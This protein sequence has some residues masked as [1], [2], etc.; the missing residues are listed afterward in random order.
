MSNT[1]FLVVLLDN[2][3]YFVALL[4]PNL[5]VLYIILRRKIHS[6]IDPSFMMFLTCSFA[7]TVPC[8]LFCLHLISTDKFVF[9]ILSELLF[10]TGFNI[11][12]NGNRLK[13]DRH[14][15]QYSPEDLHKIFLLFFLLT[16]VITLYSYS[17]SGVPIFQESRFAN[18][19]NPVTAILGRMLALPNTYLILYSYHIIL[20]D[21]ENVIKRIQVGMCFAV[22]LIISF[23]SGS[24]G[25]ILVYVA[26]YFAYSFFFKNSPIHISLKYVIIIIISPIPVITIYYGSNGLNGFFMLLFR[27]VAGGDGYWQGFVNNVIDDIENTALWYERL[28]SFIL[29]PLGLISSNAKIP[30]GSLILNQIDPGTIGLLEGA[31]SRVPLF[32]WACFRWMGIIVSFILGLIARCVAYGKTLRVPY[33]LVG[34]TVLFSLYS[35]ALSMVSDPTMFGACLIDT[36]FG[37][38]VFNSLS[39][40]FFKKRGYVVFFK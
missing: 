23:L 5:I 11:V 15:K 36:L 20:S 18:R 21:N 25:F 24:K 35:A 34:L 13:F 40:L 26:L 29:G 31:N 2:F 17:V 7:N 19:Q 3:F 38:L 10:W 37:I 33:D 8:F 27:F 4:I 14:S 12:R 30:I 28:F 1:E 6:F 39:V 16:L 32:T 22:L 9:F